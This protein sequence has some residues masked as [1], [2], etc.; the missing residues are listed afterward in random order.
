MLSFGISCDKIII[1]VK[2][3]MS[4]SGTIFLSIA[5]LAF[6]SLLMIVYFTKERMATSEN[7]VFTKLLVIS[8]VSLL[9]ELYI[10][11]MP[12]D[13]TIP[14]FVFSLKFYLIFVILW[15]SYFMEYVFI[16]TRNRKDKILIDYKK[17]YK[18]TYIIFWI[19]NVCV[20]IMLMVLP[21]YF[22]NSDTIKYSYGPSVNVTFCL[23]AIYT[24]IM[25]M[26]ILKNIK[27]LK[28]KGYLPIIFF[29]IFLTVV[30][31]VQKINPGLLLA[32]TC[33][34]LITTLLYNTIENPDIKILKELEYSKNLAEKSK[35][36][37]INTLNYM[38]KELHSSLET[39][40]LLDEDKKN[41]NELKL[42]KF[43]TEFGEKVSGLIEL[44]KINSSDN[45]VQIG[46]YEAYEM[47]EEIKELINN[48]Q[49]IS[50][51]YTFAFSKDINKV[52]FGDSEK[53]KQII[54]YV[55]KYIVKKLPRNMIIL[56]VDKLSAGNLC[57]L[58]FN[59]IIQNTKG[60]HLLPNDDMT[61]NYMSSN[62]IKDMDYEIILTLL[63]MIDGKIEEKDN[64]NDTEIIVSI[65]QKIM[66]EYD[67][68]SQDT[69]ND[70]KKVIPFNTQNKEIVLVDNNED[71]IKEI[72]KKITRYNVKIKTCNSMEEVYDYIIENNE[73]SLILID[74]FILNNNENNSIKAIKR[75]NCSNAPIVVMVTKNKEEKEKKYLKH[76]LDN[77]IIKPIDDK[78]IDII[79]K[80]YLQ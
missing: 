31:I 56:K 51:K 11:L 33:F 15:L 24:I 38:Q 76:G 27:N 72:I 22:Y 77:Y 9:S 36:E 34:A 32:N 3:K 69:R 25:F 59:F 21:I 5:S 62:Y 40:N 50:K 26:Y 57:R 7:K 44:G 14:L 37:T 28:D 35:N 74:D 20:I 63:K 73:Y 8:F 60:K 66:R 10:T 12:I 1:E 16:I 61:D 53:I 6:I 70:N 41:K 58:K 80:K 18:K 45:K 49:D 43:I 23:A 2:G 47:L 54:L 29:V 65:N 64:I 68:K 71:D 42:I 75:M 17:E 13:L 46:M 4:S 52:L 19:I 78:Q 30:A 39:I 48:E 67:V 79:M 55:S